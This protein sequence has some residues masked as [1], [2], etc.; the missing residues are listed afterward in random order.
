MRPGWWR[1]IP[2][3][4]QNIRGNVLYWNFLPPDELDELLRLF[5]TVAQK[6]LR[7]SKAFGIETGKLLR[8]DDDFDVM[9][10]FNEAYE[11]QPTTDEEMHL[12]LQKLLAENPGLEEKLNGFPNRIFTGKARGPESGQLLG[13]EG[14]AVFFCY[15][16][17]ALDREKAAELP[18]DAPAAAAWTLEA[19]RTGWYLYDLSSGQVAE[20][21]DS[22]FRL[23]KSEPT[24]PRRTVINQGT[25]KK[26]REEVEK[27]IQRDY[28]RK[29]D[30]PQHVDAVLK[31]WM[32]L[33]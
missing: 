26:A 32:E 16:L 4:A 33:S 24:T 18:S 12:A 8:P 31:A 21:A 30:A 22:M 29:V 13:A 23:I 5:G 9:K 28:L 6:T 3:T 14:Q 2:E 10:N 1:S 20:D 7:I 25:L 27:V 15:A 11:G 17:P 19:G